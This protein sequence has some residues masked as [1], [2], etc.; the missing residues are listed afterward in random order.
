MPEICLAVRAHQPFRLALAPSGALI[1]QLQ[2][3]APDALDALRALAAGGG[4]KLLAG[5]YYHSLAAVAHPTEWVAQVEM[6]RQRL[7]WTVGGRARPTVLCDAE[8]AASAETMRLARELGFEGMLVAGD[9][10]GARDAAAAPGLRLLPARLT[11]EAPGSSARPAADR[12][13]ARAA[14]GGSGGREAATILLDLEALGDD[15]TPGRPRPYATARDAFLRFT[16]ALESLAPASGA[17]RTP[18]AITEGG[19]A[20]VRAPRVA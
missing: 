14:A 1:D 9:G 3:H 6:H 7:A 20:R 8:L 19:D 12:I 13:A 4:A 5:T 15:A 11:S 16:N 2:R 18:T 10:R 17:G